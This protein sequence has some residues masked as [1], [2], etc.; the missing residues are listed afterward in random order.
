MLKLSFSALQHP[1]QYNLLLKDF[2]RS[3]HRLDF[4]PILWLL[5]DS[6]LTLSHKFSQLT[7]C[8][9]FSLTLS[10]LHTDP[11]HILYWLSS[12]TIQLNWMLA[13]LDAHRN[14]SLSAQC[15]RF[16][17]NLISLRSCW[18]KPIVECRICK[19]LRCKLFKSTRLSLSSPVAAQK[20]LFD[21]TLEPND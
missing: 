6:S 20:W 17:V 4:T 5:T 18:V 14:Y 21:H 10:W 19:L 12:K 15:L 2:W 13:N 8:T 7:V 9:N 11:S 3:L 16:L 1:A